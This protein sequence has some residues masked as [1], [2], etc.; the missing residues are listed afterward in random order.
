[1]SSAEVIAQ[2]TY[3]DSQGSFTVGIRAPYQSG[4]DWV[5]E[6]FTEG[7]DEGNVPV[8]GVDALQAIRLALSML[9]ALVETRPEAEAFG[10]T[11]VF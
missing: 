5:C 2:R 7:L 3:Q 10:M 8:V 4:D 6:L 1:M 11:G 9:D